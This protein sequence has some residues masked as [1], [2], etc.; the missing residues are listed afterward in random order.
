M[1]LNLQFNAIR[2]RAAGYW[3]MPIHR[4]K[5]IFIPPVQEQHLNLCH[6]ILYQYNIDPRYNHTIQRMFRRRCKLTKIN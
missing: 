5:Y 3:L 1:A 2:F 6:N 4:R